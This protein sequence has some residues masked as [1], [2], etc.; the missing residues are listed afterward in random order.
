METRRNDTHSPQGHLSEEQ[1]EGASVILTETKPEEEEQLLTLLL[2][3]RELLVRE[4]HS[5]NYQ[6]AASLLEQALLKVQGT[7]N[8]VME[9]QV[10]GEL[11]EVFLSLDN[12]KKSLDYGLKCLSL[13]EKTGRKDLEAL[14]SALIGSAYSKLGDLRRGLIIIIMS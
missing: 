2:S 12:Y 3:A 13:S 9:A 4:K 5:N 6:Q 10:C 14:A 8:E 7:S 11:A 1:R